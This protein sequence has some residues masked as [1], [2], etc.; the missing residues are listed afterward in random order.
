MA[1]FPDDSQS[2]V[3]SSYYPD[4]PHDFFDELNTAITDARDRHNVRVFNLSLNIETPIS[5]KYYSTYAHL[6]D[7]IAENN[8][9]LI[10][11]S[12]GNIDQQDWRPE[13]P[14]DTAVALSNLAVARNDD[15]LIPAESVRNI[16]VAALNPPS[17]GRCLPF[18]PACY[19]RRGLGLRSGIKPDFAHVGGSGFSH[20]LRGHGLY[21]ISPDGTVIDGCGTSYAT[22][23][24]AKTAARLVQEIE[25][26]I[27]R[28]TLIALLVHNAEIPT[29][30]HSKD[31]DLIAQHLVGFG[32]PKPANQ[33]LETDEHSITLV[34]ASLI[35]KRQQINFQFSWPLS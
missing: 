12:A 3:F 7:Q 30:L 22:P 4:G 20:P 28:E 15:L 31:F 8:N 16:T 14:K 13:W 17:Q 32:V 25:G 35:Q 11:I 29:P 10:F 1:I 24:V 34:F 5:S 21:S 9:V 6:L 23:L 33:I 27:S 26:E 19:S 2:E 18:A